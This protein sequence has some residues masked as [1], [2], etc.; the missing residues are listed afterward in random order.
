MTFLYCNVVKGEK[1]FQYCEGENFLNILKKC[2][3]RKGLPTVLQTDGRPFPIVV[4]HLSSFWIT[5]TVLYF[6]DER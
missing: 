6:I 2:A 5:R 4:F 3:K 1:V